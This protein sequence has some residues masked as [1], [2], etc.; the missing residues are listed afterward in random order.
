MTTDGDIELSSTLN[1]LAAL[2]GSFVNPNPDDEEWHGPGG[3]RVRGELEAIRRVTIAI[4]QWAES[5]GEQNMANMSE[6]EFRASKSNS[7]TDKESRQ[8]SAPGDEALADIDCVNDPDCDPTTD[9]VHKKQPPAS[10]MAI[11]RPSVARFVRDLI[12]GRPVRLPVA[13]SGQFNPWI[14]SFTQR[15]QLPTVL[16]VAGSQFQFAAAATQFERLRDLFERAASL[17]IG[18]GLKKLGHDPALVLRG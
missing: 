15:A 18:E 13:A 14:F 9:G 4:S 5:L 17:L 11:V 2:I 16:L 3:P 7:R 12:A 6:S 8:D 10:T 1:L